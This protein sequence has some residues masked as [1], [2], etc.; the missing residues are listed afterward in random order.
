VQTAS[1][2]KII[3]TVKME[4]AQENRMKISEVKKRKNKGPVKVTKGMDVAL[5]SP[6]SEAVVALGTVQHADT[7][8]FIEVMINMVLKRT[9]RLP[10]AKGRMT[11]LGHAEARSVQWPRKNV[12]STSLL[13][14]ENVN[15]HLFST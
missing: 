5:T 15:Y 4:K 1:V 6:Y 2:N 7:D 8:E 13:P 11:L 10:Q 14:L 9:T 12:S 3:K